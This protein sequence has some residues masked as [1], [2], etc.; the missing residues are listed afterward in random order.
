MF[1]NFFNFFKVKEGFNKLYT[2]DEIDKM[3]KFIM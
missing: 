3:N 2:Q 1:K